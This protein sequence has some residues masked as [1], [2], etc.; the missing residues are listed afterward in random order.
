MGL[1]PYPHRRHGAA[2][3]RVA[4]PEACPGSTGWPYARSAG[5][6]DGR[7]CTRRVSGRHNAVGRPV[8]RLGRGFDGTVRVQPINGTAAAHRPAWALPDSRDRDGDAP[9]LVPDRT[10]AWTVGVLCGRCD[11]SA[12]VCARGER[13]YCL[14]AYGHAGHSFQTVGSAGHDRH[15]SAHAQSDV[16]RARCSTKDQ[17]ELPRR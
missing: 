6:R 13:C 17:P 8:L 3:W 7:S 15:L 9:S 4:T 1:N 16:S 5:P 12:W 11:D 2:D 10:G 14:Q